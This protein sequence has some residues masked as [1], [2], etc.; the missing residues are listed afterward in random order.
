MKRFEPIAKGVSGILH[1]GDYNPEQWLKWKD[2]IWKE[3]LRIAKEAGLNSLS[4]GIFSWAMLEPEE[5]RFCFDWLD[6]V[7]DGLHKNGLTAV[8]ATPSGARP[9]WLAQKYPEVLRVRADGHRNAFG[10][11]HNHCLS[12]QVYRAKVKIINTELARRYG[13]H[14][15]LG[16][17]HISNEYSGECHCPLCQAVF[18][19]YLRA[20][21]GSLEALNEA[22]WSAFWSHR[23]TDFAQI[24]APSPRGENDTHGLTLDWKRFTTEQTVDFYLH[25]IGPLKACAPQIPCTTN[26]MAGYT[27]L[28]YAR[29]AEVLDVVSWDNYPQWTGSSEKDEQIALETGYFHDLM[30]GLKKKPFLLMESSPSAT[31]WRPV[32]KLHRPGVHI[33]QSLQAIAHGADSVQYFQ[34]RKGRGGS[35]K[36]HGAVIDHVGHENTR[37]F[38]EIKKFGRE[39]LPQLDHIV[40]APKPAKVALVHDY[41]NGWAIEGMRG[42]LQGETGYTKTLMAHYG[43]FWRQ[44]VPVEIIDQGASLEGYALVVAPMSYMLREGF[45]DRVKAYVEGGG[46]FVTSY[47]SGYVNDTDLCFLGGF[48]GPLK[49]VLG[50]WAEELDALYPGDEN[51]I[52]WN[53]KQYRAF[54]LCELIHAQGAE[55]L[56]SYAGDFY[57]GRPALTAMTLG[58]GK[59]YYIAAR[60]GADFLDDFYQSLLGELKLP[61]YPGGGGLSVQIRAH[62][63]GE[64]LFVINF[65]AQERLFKL[66]GEEIPV[67]AHGFALI[68][69]KS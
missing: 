50:I 6:E 35:E 69:R 2:G 49:E 23:Y 61:A 46:R 13:K 9:A 29:L 57:A 59:A 21:Y 26:L 32:A 18:R 40:G 8:L 1:G 24:E 68:E 58:K 10:G 12:S 65:G 42:A 28:D 45:A 48:P 54:E 62:E 25:E 5:G 44:G 33:L 15:A 43:A 30:Y 67:E 11:R 3:D 39:I 41:V 55:A 53:G 20:K 51:A 47:F 56:G 4:V 60:T 34:M 31:N 27:G 16:L 7:M 22:W 64:T 52:C 37:V 19:E 38:G 66:D 36:F 17:W 63:K 14:P